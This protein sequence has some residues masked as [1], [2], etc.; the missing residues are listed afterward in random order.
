MRL[1]LALL[2]PLAAFA[3]GPGKIV[4]KYT[5]GDF[6]L[7]ADPDSPQWRG[8]GG[9]FAENGPLGKPT[10]GH[11]TEI[12]SRWSDKNIYFL[13]IC[14]YDKL[15]LKPSPSASTETN[16]LWEWDVAEVFI[17]ADFDRPRHYRE[18]QVSPQ[19]EWV[20]LD[21]DRDHPL[22]DG[23]WKWNSGFTVKARIDE[24]K[25]VWYGEM[26]IPIES[27]NGTNGKPA[28]AKTGSEM[29]INFYRL[30]G[31]G[32][33]RAGI[34]WQPTGQPSYHVPEAFGRILF[35]R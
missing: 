30:Q 24:S 3:D 22:P 19:S 7:T 27:V 2:L 23:G 35:A 26:K 18:Y 25:K 20:D 6:V 10:P 13:F 16:K 1:S 31:P 14:P 4:S 33:Q 9:V 34:A 5:S 15:N 11:R 12:R 28:V 32:P 29:R 17:G 8:I 21:I